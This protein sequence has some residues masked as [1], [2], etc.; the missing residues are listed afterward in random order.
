MPD[1]PPLPGESDRR[2]IHER[3]FGSNEKQAFERRLVTCACAA[4]EQLHLQQALY[5]P[6]ATAR[7]TPE[8]RSRLPSGVRGLTEEEQIQPA[9]SVN[10]LKLDSCEERPS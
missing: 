1:R 2:S 10:T 3:E 8:T 4:I 5:R 6:D 7:C 9:S